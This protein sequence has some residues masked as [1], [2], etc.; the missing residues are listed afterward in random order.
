MAML[1][2]HTGCIRSYAIQSDQMSRRPNPFAG[3]SK[4]FTESLHCIDA[5][6]YIPTP[7]HTNGAGVLWQHYEKRS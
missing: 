3:D 1:D 6:E 4:A 7:N 5:P 2:G